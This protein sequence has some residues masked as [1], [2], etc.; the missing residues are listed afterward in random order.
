[1]TNHD[2]NVKILISS[3]PNW[4]TKTQNTCQ[5]NLKLS[6][7]AFVLAYAASVWIDNWVV[8]FN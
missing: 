1:M 5:S 4:S 7:K 8:I 6:V 3:S 2:E